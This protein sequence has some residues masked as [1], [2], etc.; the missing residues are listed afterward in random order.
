MILTIII[1]EIGRLTTRKQMIE[2]LTLR[3]AA[4][5][6]LYLNVLGKR[7]DGYHEIESIMQ[8]ISLYD[9]LTLR[10][11]KQGIRILSNESNIPVNRENICY[12]AA[13][14]FL[15]KTNLNKGLEI[16]IHKTIPVKAGLGGGSAN[17]AATLWGMNKLFQSDVLLSDLKE[18]ASLLGAD[19]PF[20]LQGGTS[21]V[22]GKGE[23]LIPLPP[24]KNGWLVLLDPTVPISTAWVY[25]RVRIG[26]TKK[27]LSARL[28]AKSIRKEGLLGIGNSLYNKLEEVV[29][30]RFPLVGSVK[31]KMKEAGARGALMT[32]SGSTVFAIVEDRQKGQEIISK[33]KGMGRGYLVQPIDRSLKEV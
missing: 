27:K 26:L 15:Q 33:L 7:N 1:E 24:L 17:A 12:K 13:K 10:P 25:E 18:W 11:L 8:S 30:E 23:V 22:R 21:L 28:L 16:E 2:R 6:N 31:E 14:L 5:I 32:G 19:I 20:C 29:L 4:K 3:V 9:R